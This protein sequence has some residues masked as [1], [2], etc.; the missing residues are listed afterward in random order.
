MGKMPDYILKAAANY[1]K[2][3]DI[4]SLNFEV[5]E[6]EQLR[7]VGLDNPECVRILRAE[8]KRRQAAA[9]LPDADELPTFEP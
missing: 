5:G 4:V 6:R 7:A 9:E 3:H 2:K 8:L 1:R